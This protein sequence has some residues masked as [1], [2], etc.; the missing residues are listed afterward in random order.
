M[1]EM[2]VADPYP[3][4]GIKRPCGARTLLCASTSA[5]IAGEISLAARPERNCL[6]LNI[7]TRTY[8]VAAL[9]FHKI[10]DKALS[11]HQPQRQYFT[12]A[13]FED[14]SFRLLWYEK[15]GLW[16]TRQSRKGIYSL[17]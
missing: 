8:S 15:R 6:A 2:I 4:E 10:F 11:N 16:T 14:E 3:R 5:C 13:F 7:H 9:P 17:P 1:A 12:R